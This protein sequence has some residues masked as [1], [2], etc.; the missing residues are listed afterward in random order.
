M[1]CLH[2]CLQVT[3]QEDPGGEAMNDQVTRHPRRR[4]Q[5]RGKMATACHPGDTATCLVQ[6]PSDIFQACCP[7]EVPQTR[8]SKASPKLVSQSAGQSDPEGF[9]VSEELGATPPHPGRQY[10]TIKDTTL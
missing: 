4:S 7:L 2:T 10:F 8:L 1:R 3:P 6:S 5:S 9:T